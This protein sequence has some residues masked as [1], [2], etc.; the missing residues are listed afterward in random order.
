MEIDEKYINTFLE[1]GLTEEEEQKIRTAMATDEAL[2]TRIG[3]RKLE[4]LVVEEL[5]QQYWAKKVQFQESRY[6]KQIRTRRLLA[7]AAAAAVAAIAIFLVVFPPVSPDDN[8]TG[9]IAFNTDYNTNLKNLTI[10]DEFSP[11]MLHGLWEASITEQPG[12]ILNLELEMLAS[13][14]FNISVFYTLNNLQKDGDKIT[15]RGTYLLNGKQLTLNLNDTSI[16]RAAGASPFETAP[17][18]LWLKSKRLFKQE[19]EIVGLDSDLLI[20][21]YGPSEGLTWQKK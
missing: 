11:T 7:Y 8:Y 17:I 16:K 6:K 13:N 4:M 20:L 18:E 15:A 9:P 5:D 14:D 12:L 3:Q 21:K 2:A 10:I 1:G 19:M